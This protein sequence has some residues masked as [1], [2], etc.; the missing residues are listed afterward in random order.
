MAATNR[1]R[2]GVVRRS[3]TVVPAQIQKRVVL[4]RY[5]LKTGV[6]RRG[7]ATNSR[8][9]PT[10]QLLMRRFVSKVDSLRPICLI[11]ILK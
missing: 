7:F 10:S 4:T 1:G 8:V 9:H 11:S 3:D 2:G 6:D 5:H